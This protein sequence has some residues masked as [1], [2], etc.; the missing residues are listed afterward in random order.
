MLPEKVRLEK[1]AQKSVFGKVCL[2]K[3]VWK[4]VLRKVCLEKCA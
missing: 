1:R 2:E 4:S 3:R